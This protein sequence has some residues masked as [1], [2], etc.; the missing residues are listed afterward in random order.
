MWPAPWPR[1]P[2]IHRALLIAGLGARD[3]ADAIRAFVR[4]H[5]MPAMVTYKAKGVIPDRDAWFAGVFTNGALEQELLNEADAVIAV[6][7]DRVELLPRPWTPPQMVFDIADDI[8]ASLAL[9]AEPVKQSTWDLE[10][11]QRTLAMQRHRLIESSRSSRG[12]APADVIRI[13]SDALPDARVTVDAGAHMFPATLLWPIAEP[14]GMLISNG[15]STMGFALPAA[16]GA[17]L[18]DG[19]RP[20]VALTGDGGLL[21]C[22]GEL[23]TIVRER[24]RVVVI[25]FNDRALSLIDVKQRQRQFARDGVALGEVRWT[26]VAEGVGLTSYCATNADELERSLGLAL[27]SGGPALVDVAVDPSS[28]A[29]MLQVVRG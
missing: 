25:V 20:V 2:Q 4:R 22:A 16:I 12:L 8:E 11:L 19:E 6:G 28:Y 14:N 9:M 3:H 27:A 7:L 10:A 15:L 21:M 29:A 5:H 17:A 23:L 18:V 24:L 26:A 1:R 13:A